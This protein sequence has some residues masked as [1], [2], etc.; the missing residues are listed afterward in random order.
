VRAGNLI[1]G[2]LATTLQRGV[3]RSQEPSVFRTA[4]LLSKATPMRANL[5]IAE[6]P[7]RKGHRNDVLLVFARRNL[8]RDLI[9]SAGTFGN[10]AFRVASE[11]P[12]Y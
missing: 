4:A 5:A 9:G 7:L 6:L 8:L 10:I 11:P 1:L 2:A 12:R 3:L